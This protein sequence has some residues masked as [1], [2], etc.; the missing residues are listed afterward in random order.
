MIDLH[1]LNILNLRKY[2]KLIFNIKIKYPFICFYIIFIS[3]YI[4][5]II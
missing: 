2:N 1:W 5:I 3:I 4:N